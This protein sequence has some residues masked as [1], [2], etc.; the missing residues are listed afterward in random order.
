[1]ILHCFA[2]S[3]LYYP[4][5]KH[6]ILNSIQS[7]LWSGSCLPSS[8]VSATCCPTASLQTMLQA[9]W[10]TFK[11]SSRAPSCPWTFGY[12]VPSAWHVFPYIWL[13]CVSFQILPS[14]R[15]TFLTPLQSS[16]RLCTPSVY[17]H[18]PWMGSVIA[19]FTL[20]CWTSNMGHTQPCLP[21]LAWRWF[22]RSMQSHKMNGL[23]F[24][25]CQSHWK[26]SMGKRFNAY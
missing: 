21:A 6:T 14:F 15:K 23:A 10:W 2:W 13:I 24:L 1:M 25:V 12:A 7:H 3:A 20:D 17:S 8:I 19:L 11:P 16:V 22:E 26:V 4:Q 18:I 9:S 5:D